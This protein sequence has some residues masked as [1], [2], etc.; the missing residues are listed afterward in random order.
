[1]K[2]RLTQFVTALFL[3]AAV[4]AAQ[5]N[6]GADRPPLLGFDREGSARQRQLERQFDSFINKE[7]L[8]AWMKRLSARPHH[9]GSAYDKENADFIAG[10]F[11]SWGYETE[12]ERFDVVFPT[13]K[14]RLLEMTSP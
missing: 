8:R 4:V 5:S 1:M 7:D 11:R 14:T 12:I 2:L 10:L 13:P 9:L 3:C 6:S